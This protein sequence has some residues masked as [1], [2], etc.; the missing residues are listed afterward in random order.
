[1]LITIL[2]VQET[3]VVSQSMD[4]PLATISLQLRPAPPAYMGRLSSKVGAKQYIT[5]VVGMFDIIL[6]MI[7]PMVAQFPDSHI[8]ISTKGIMV[9]EIV[10]IHKRNVERCR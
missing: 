6:R 4:H 3:E 7:Q 8:L 5:V 10:I 1:M 9:G 2:Y